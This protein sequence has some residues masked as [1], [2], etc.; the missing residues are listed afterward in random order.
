M[1][2]EE[3]IQQQQVQSTALQ[4]KTTKTQA[5]QVHERERCKNQSGTV[6]IEK[7]CPSRKYRGRSACGKNPSLLTIITHILLG[8]VVA[9]NIMC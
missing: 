8:N 6:Y 3:D 5:T 9:S 7:T 2:K 1:I 4:R